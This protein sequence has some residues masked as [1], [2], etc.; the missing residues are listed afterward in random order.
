MPRQDRLDA[1][2]TL[3]HVMGRGIERTNIFRNKGDK[4]GFASRVVDLCQ[5]GFLCL[6]LGADG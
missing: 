2:G 5:A 3:H 4:R 6:C 1:P